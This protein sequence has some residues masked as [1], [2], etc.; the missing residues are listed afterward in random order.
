MEHRNK[1]KPKKKGCLLVVI[2][3]IVIVSASLLFLKFWLDSLNNRN[4][5]IVAPNVQT[6]IASGL[7]TDTP[8]ADGV[9][10][11]LDNPAPI[12]SAITFFD[13]TFIV[14]EFIRPANQ[15]VAE[16]SGYNA[17][18]DSDKE[19]VAIDLQVICE[20]QPDEK[21][22]FGPGNFR[23]VGSRRLVYDYDSLLTSPKP[24]EATEFYGGTSVR[25]VIPFLVY[26]TD[27]DLLLVYYDESFFLELE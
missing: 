8:A 19:Y 25:G 9:G 11:S 5:K 14:K 21:C 3:L 4:I 24:F 17:Q 1:A 16:L 13:K 6:Q 18:Y 23:L 20:K 22:F 7:P 26:K 10:F 27:A 2:F 12:N 15:L